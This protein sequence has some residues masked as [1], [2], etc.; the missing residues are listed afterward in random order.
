[1]KLNDSYPTG[2]CHDWEETL[3]DCSET[4]PDDDDKEDV[5]EDDIESMVRREQKWFAGTDF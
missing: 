3:P 2:E 5:V 1:M 4:L